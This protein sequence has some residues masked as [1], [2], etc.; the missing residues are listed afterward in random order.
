MTGSRQ[1]SEVTFSE[2]G[3]LLSDA[4]CIASLVCLG[5]I[6]VGCVAYMSRRRAELEQAAQARP[7]NPNIA[8]VL[9]P[10]VVASGCGCIANI[11][12]KAVGEL[13]KTKAGFWHV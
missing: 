11:A 12:L 8:E 7:S 5:C 9:L 10:A 2:L 3:T 4:K 1:S 6:I 13:L